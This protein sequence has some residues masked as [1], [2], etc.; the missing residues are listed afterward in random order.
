[1]KT[2]GTEAYDKL[3][4]HFMTTLQ[5]MKDVIIFSDME[6]QMGQYHIIDA[7]KGV[8]ESI[9]KDN[10][11]FDL[12]T[13]LKES[14]R[15]GEDPRN[16]KDGFSGW[17]LDKYKF[18]PMFAQTWKY[19]QDAKWYIYVEADTG[20]N[21][22][23]LRKFLDMLDPK[24]PL[25]VGSPTYLDIEFAHGGTGYILSGAAM[26]QGIGKHPDMQDK[27]DKTV[28]DI[29]CGDRMIAKVL[30]EEKIK[31][32][33]AW[34]MLNGE[35]PLTVPFTE[36]H[37]C[38]PILTMHHMTAQEVSQVWNFEQQR[39]A[40]GNHVRTCTLYASWLLFLIRYNRIQSSGKTFTTTSS[41]ILFFPYAKTGPTLVMT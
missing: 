6:M 29:C 21:W 26:E 13:Q 24:Q 27:Y 33:K 1:M 19:R 12:Y 11:D 23:N 32:T 35:K 38:A 34:P 30:E 36:A 16:L 31:L 20:M 25:Y 14:E 10:P 41:T 15:L 3:P 8:D 22:S 28:H 9:K 39:K 7:L 4:I 18:L 17:N 2:G 5:C 37:W 40:D